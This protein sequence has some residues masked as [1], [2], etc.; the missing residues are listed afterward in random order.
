M[1]MGSGIESDQVCDAYLAACRLD[2]TAMKPGNVSEGSAGHGMTAE[3]FHRSA[4][5][6]AD[7]ISDPELSLGARIYAAV[8]ATRSAV[9]CNTNLGIVLLCA[10]LAQAALQAYPGEDLHQALQVVLRDATVD[11]AEQV[12]AAIRL[13][14][15]GGLGAADEHDVRSAAE[16][17]LRK[18]MAAAADRDRIASQY[19]SGFADLFEDALPRVTAAR[20]AGGDERRAVTDL[21]LYL[22]SRFPDSHVQRKHGV[23]A[24]VALRDDSIGI[25]AD[26]RADPDADADERLQAFDRRLKCAGINPGT[27]ADLTVATLFLERLLHAA[28]LNPGES[29]RATLRQLRLAS[30]GA[31]LISMLLIGES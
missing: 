6:S 30:S 23:D 8:S 18:A 9:G 29:R 31:P 4:H 25:Y 16:V 19:A 15:P 17:R 14:N 20:S 10:P 13:A 11:D 26:W 21:Y 12:F 7:A 1:K 22:L 2:V 28:A 27:S 5:V 24:A 3:V